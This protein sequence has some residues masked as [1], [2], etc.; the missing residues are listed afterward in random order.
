[1]MTVGFET[2]CVSA[3]DDEAHEHDEEEEGELRELKEG[4]GGVKKHR[5]ER[6]GG[7]HL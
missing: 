7:L 3:S 6:G 4:E 1:M 5:L 2:C